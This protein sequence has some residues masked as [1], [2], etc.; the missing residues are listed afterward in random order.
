MLLVHKLLQFALIISDSVIGQLHDLANHNLNK[1]G[2]D[3]NN[4]RLLAE[5]GKPGKNGLRV[6][7]TCV[8]FIFIYPKMSTKLLPSILIG[9]SWEDGFIYWNLNTKKVIVTSEA[10]VS[11]HNRK[12]KMVWMH[13]EAELGVGPGGPPTPTPL[14]FLGKKN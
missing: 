14:L 13:P 2:Q 7:P 11:P 1:F 5:K 3:F 10:A 4:P 12:K 6:N 9:L 8:D